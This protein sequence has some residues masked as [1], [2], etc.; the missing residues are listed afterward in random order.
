MKGRDLG[1]NQAR[2]HA[3]PSSDDVVD[4]LEKLPRYTRQ[5]SVHREPRRDKHLYK[6]GRQAPYGRSHVGRT[7]Q[8]CLRRRADALAESRH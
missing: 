8:G 7:A 4:I 1:R 2:A 5:V 3:V 6:H